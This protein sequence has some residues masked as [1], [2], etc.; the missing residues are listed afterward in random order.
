MKLTVQRVS[1]ASVLKAGDPNPVG[2]INKGLMILLGIGK[3]D[4]EDTAR[5]MAQKIAKL[6][7]M[8]DKKGKMNLSILD[9]KGDILVVSQFTLY[10][11]TS[12]GNRP[13]FVDAMDPSKAE[14]IYN[15][16]IACLRQLG[17]NVQTGS[18]GD[19]MNIEMK[20]DGPVT[21]NI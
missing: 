4:N 5:S 21:I 2:K 19:Y 17:I 14:K 10:A 11:D 7:I 15:Y 1:G 16:F 8:Q 9:T 18:F 3:N 6:R 12:K 20:L 13:S